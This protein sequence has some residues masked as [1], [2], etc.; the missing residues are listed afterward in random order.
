MGIAA[1]HVRHIMS[2]QRQRDPGQLPP[3]SCKNGGGKRSGHGVTSA[4]GT[5]KRRSGRL[6]V[7]PGADQAVGEIKVRRCLLLGHRFL[8][9]RLPLRLAVGKLRA[10]DLR[11][12]RMISQ[13]FAVAV[14]IG[15]G[16]ALGAAVR[17]R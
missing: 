5:L 10:G 1:G 3:L 14:E 6:H 12:K 11:R 9:Q 17:W 15:V 2:P 4:A 16:P 7:Q 8:G 13:R